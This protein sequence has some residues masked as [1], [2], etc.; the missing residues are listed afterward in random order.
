MQ[1]PRTPDEMLLTAA[2]SGNTAEVRTA[3][4][5]GAHVNAMRSYRWQY[6]S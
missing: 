3:L 4:A 6:C 2:E 1:L 5:Q